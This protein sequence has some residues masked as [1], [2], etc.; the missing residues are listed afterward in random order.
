M[1]IRTVIAGVLWIILGLVQYYLY[2]KYNNYMTK[3]IS[4]TMMV[5]GTITS[6]L[7]TINVFLQSYDFGLSISALIIPAAIYINYKMKQY[8]NGLKVID[9]LT[10]KG[11]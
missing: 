6:I 9:K 3:V 2:R 4:I 1:F 10:K 8:E 11:K 5:T 7:G